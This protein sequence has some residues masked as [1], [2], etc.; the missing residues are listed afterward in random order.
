LTGHVNVPRRRGAVTPL[1]EEWIGCAVSL[2][3]GRLP[4]PAG[5]RAA[6]AAP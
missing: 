3:E 5:V 6:A 4:P 1:V 2:L